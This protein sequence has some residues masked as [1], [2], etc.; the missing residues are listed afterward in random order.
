VSFFVTR[1]STR[2]PPSTMVVACDRFDTP[3]LAKIF[4]ECVL[5]VLGVIFFRRQIS[6][7]DKP[8]PKSRRI[9]RLLQL[10]DLS[11]QDVAAAP[12]SFGPARQFS[13]ASTRSIVC[14]TSVPRAVLTR[15]SLRSRTGC[16]HDIIVGPK[17]T[18]DDR[19]DRRAQIPG[20]PPIHD[21]VLIWQA[22]VDNQQIGLPFSQG[23][24]RLP[25]P[26]QLHRP[27]QT[28]SV[29]SEQAGQAHRGTNG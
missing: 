15:S 7:L 16:G 1:R 27:L 14:R 8:I 10:S 19:A 28:A 25:R 18:E 6:R 17:C 21:S 22:Q 24:E 5:T 9:F 26:S 3:S 29:P 12:E 13:P 11:E 20:P 23:I 2:A 4:R